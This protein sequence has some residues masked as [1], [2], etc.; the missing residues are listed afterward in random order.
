MVFRHPDAQSFVV[1]DLTCCQLLELWARSD[2]DRLAFVWGPTGQTVTYAELWT[3]S[4]KVAR[5]LQELGLEKG[6][7]VVILSPTCPLFPETFY[8]VLRA[9][10]VAV[11]INPLSK[12]GEVQRCLPDTGAQVVLGSQEWVAR[13]RDAGLASSLRS[14][15]SLEDLRE[16][17]QAWK[18][19]EPVTVDP[20][21]DLACILYSSGTTGRPKGACLTHRNV[22][23][24][25]LASR[26]TGL[27]N[28]R[29]RYVHFLPLCHC[30]GLLALFNAGVCGGAVQILVPRF[31]PQEVLRLVEAYAAREL[32]TVPPALR[33]LVEAAERIRFGYRGLRFLN[34]AG[35]P[36]DSQLARRASE[37]FGC[38]ATEHLGMTESAGPMNISVPPQPVKPGS[39]GPPVPGLEE[40]VVDPDTGVDLRPGEMGELLVRGPMVTAGYW[41]NPQ[42]NQEA[43][44]GEW[45]RT[46]DLVWFDG[47]GYLWWVDRRKEMIKYKGYSIAPVEVEEVL[48]RHPAV[49]EACVVPKPHPELGEI[50]KA[51]VVR[52]GE[53]TA[54]ELMRF[55][56]EHLAP[57]KN[58][59]PRTN[60][61]AKWSLWTS[62]QG[63]RLGRSCVGSWRT[64]SAPWWAAAPAG[65]THEGLPA[66]APPVGLPGRGGALFF[67]SGKTRSPSTVRRSG[68]TPWEVCRGWRPI[69]VIGRRRREARC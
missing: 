32:F 29:S 24:N 65:R 28:N 15:L 53:V 10:G 36:L 39:V 22:V 4:G 64:G 54:E 7:P 26:A 9:G 12:L 5:A 45:F 43:F 50:P 18:E 51:F 6:K 31:E 3:K 38:P 66:L 44:I 25:L 20:R 58:T 34:T 61:C 47:D 56:E 23:A 19:P 69:R 48:R 49:R 57:Y 8:G 41:N 62:C 33:E 27:I 16:I 30:A 59:W 55:A 37:V 42:A 52:H 11:P 60:G 1:P 40:R 63:L 68:K 17:S 14:L 2:P 67:E 35:L 21:H 46:G 13:L